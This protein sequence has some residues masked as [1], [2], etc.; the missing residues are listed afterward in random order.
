MRSNLTRVLIGILSATFIVFLGASASFAE[1][2][3]LIGGALSLTGVQ[4]PL[5]EPGLK[6]AQVAVKYLNEHGGILGK[7]VK[8]VNIDGKSD[9]VTVGNAAVELIDQ[10][11][12]L[13]VKPKK[14]VSS[15]FLPA[16]QIRCIAPG[17]WVTNSLHYP[18]GT[19][20]WELSVQNMLLKNVVGKLP[21]SL[22]IS[23][24]LIPKV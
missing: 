17:L 2:E 12:K 5:D 6:G 23:L 13:M 7:K 18:C 22:P 15:V 3:I 14:P 8:F 1:D 20:P 11:A 16:P 24:L 9:P 19:P 10:G 21:T 4:A